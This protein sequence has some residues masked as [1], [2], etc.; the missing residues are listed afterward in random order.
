MLG[1]L[2]L[3]PG[4]SLTVGVVL[5]LVL[6]KGVDEGCVY[7]YAGQSSGDDADPW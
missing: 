3:V 7:L 4:E 2:M 6:L 1:L 5:F